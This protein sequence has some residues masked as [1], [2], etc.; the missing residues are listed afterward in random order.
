M[1]AKRKKKE[2]PPG[3]FIPAPARVVAILQ[4]CVAF[5]LIL[6]ALSYP[7]MGLL[8]EHK[9]R[10][11]LYRTV[12]GD[13]GLAIGNPEIR[14]RL[15]ANRE[16]FS[17]LGEEERDSVIAHYNALQA[18][19]Q[20]T[21]FQ[22]LGKSVHI[23]LFEWPIFELS[24]VILA[25][26][27]SIMLL[28]RIEGAASASWLLPIL[29]ICYAVNNHMNGVIIYPSPD[30]KLF[31]TEEVI[32]RDYLQNELPN[33]IGGQHQAL[34]HG[35]KIYLI[36]EWAHERPS[37]EPAEFARQVDAGEF[38]FNLARL[39]II[40]KTPNVPKTWHEKESLGLLLIYFIWNVLFAW[41]A[42]R[43]FHNKHHAHIQTT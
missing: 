37:S 9:S 36:Q 16:H 43:S 42:F 18:S 4:L 17:L 8:F 25:V 30:E 14:E 10:L 33:D 22:K 24:W 11:L 38:L 41:I 3:T 12:M 29:V 21:F 40:A 39:Q 31:P 35:W 13:E 2:Y 6:G 20:T 34:L 32:V 28:L 19:D 23:L 15:Q 5:T 1:F 7:F 27:I 26:V